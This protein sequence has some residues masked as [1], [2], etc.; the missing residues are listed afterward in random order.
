MSTGLVYNSETSRRSDPDHG[1]QGYIT[2]VPAPSPSQKGGQYP[3][4]SAI[5]MSEAE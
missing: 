1:K 4:L 5:V 2:I 3:L